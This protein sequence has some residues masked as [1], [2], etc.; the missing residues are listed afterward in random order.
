MSILKKVKGLVVNINNI[1]PRISATRMYIILVCISML[2]IMF[3][4]AFE[5]IDIYN[6]REQSKYSIVQNYS[7]NKIDDQDMPAGRRTEYKWKLQNTN[8]NY[9]IFYVLHQYV[10]VYF[11]GELVY[12]LKPNNDNSVGK[13]ISY[14]WVEIPLYPEDEGVEVCVEIIPAYNEV[15]NKPVEFFIGSN[16]KIYSDQLRNDLTEILLSLLA[17]GIGLRFM[18]I[19]IVHKYKR[20]ENTNMVYLGLFSISFGIWRITDVRSASLIFNK[21]PMALS[22]IS[23]IMLL[24]SILPW[25][26]SI[27]KQF[28]KKSYP[29]L[30]WCHVISCLGILG[31]IILQILNIL[32]LRETLS[33]AHGI[34]VIVSLMTVGTVIYEG[35]GKKLDRKVKILYMCLIQC[36]LGMGIDLSYYYIKGSSKGLFYTL[37]A[38]IIYVITMGYIS[39][40]DINKKA[41]VDM[42][43]GVYNKARCN[44]I[45]DENEVIV[46]SLGIIMF[47]LNRLKY[48]NDTFGHEKGDAVISEFANILR[49][50]I[51]NQD[52]VGRFGGDEFIVVLKEADEERIKDIKYRVLNTVEQY[53]L[54]NHCEHLSYSMGYAL[55]KDYPGTSLRELLKKADSFMYRNKKIY[56]ESIEC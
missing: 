19:S 51:S 27:K 43:T 52:F 53:N 36:M 8:N 34:I 23:I 45:L 46:N 3:I 17:V 54:K 25:T 5:N 28:L 44:E 38:F 16:Y 14:N 13:T 40:R 37:I 32:D 9:L 29:I 22:Y 7:E 18:I 39:I 35:K 12:S 2:L 50:S 26:F 20:N 4:S 6:N 15:V 24:I 31:I 55:S 42:H 10:E 49:S 56:Y 21:N 48:I 33:F 47:D 30:E 41:N 1:N 11:D